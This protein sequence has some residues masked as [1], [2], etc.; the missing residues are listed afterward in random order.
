MKWADMFTRLGLDWTYA[1]K[2][3]VRTEITEGR[4]TRTAVSEHEADFYIHGLGVFVNVRECK[5]NGDDRGMPDVRDVALATGSHGIHAYLDGKFEL[6]DY[7]DYRERV[8]EADEDEKGSVRFAPSVNATLAQCAKCN[9]IYVYANDGWRGCR[10]CGHF[11]GD[12]TASKTY[13]GS[14]GVFK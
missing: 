4:Y 7:C 1:P 5:I 10:N 8:N 9:E 3:S 6:Y 13:S 11:A 2:V 14:E 12:K